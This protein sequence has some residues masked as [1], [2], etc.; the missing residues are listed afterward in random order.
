[1]SSNSADYDFLA[2]VR[3]VDFTQFEA[4]PTC[5]EALAWLGAEV[6][7]I[8]NPRTGD[9]GR[10][11][12]PG[13][14]D[15]DPWYFHQ[16][17][18][19]KKSLSINLKSPRGLEIVKSLLKQADVTVENMAPGTIERLG[20]G[21]DEVK[22]INPGIVYCQ[23]KGFGAGS[24]YEKSLAF[25]MIAQAAGG[26]FSVTGEAN[27]PPVK[28]G[29]SFGDTGTGMLMAISILGALYKRQKTGQGRRLQ[30]AM[31]DAMIHYMRVPFSRTQ[32]TGKAQLRSGSSRSVPGGLVPSALYPCKPGGPNDYVYVFCSRA[33]AD[34]WRRLLKAIE[35]EDLVG[36][37]RYDSGQARSERAAEVDELIS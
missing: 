24:P 26:T 35:R 31:Q 25:D 1:M 20:L 30:V 37:A 18:A 27:Q 34:H 10:R 22:A 2:G 16:F 7:K 17:N 33:N 13:K 5:T 36:D 28:P 9:P 19:N 4:G 29:P 6:V 14:P 11:L 12:Q 32:L 21:Y 3:V 8:E 15:N 23:V